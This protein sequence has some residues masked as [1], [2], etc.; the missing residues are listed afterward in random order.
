[1]KFNL[2][3]VIFDRFLSPPPPRRGF[4]SRF[5]GMAGLEIQEIRIDPDPG[6]RRWRRR[7]R[8]VG[9]DRILITLIANGFQKLV[10]KRRER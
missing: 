10:E 2:M 6:W 1:M 9:K 4:R 5:I 8:I 3:G 7:R